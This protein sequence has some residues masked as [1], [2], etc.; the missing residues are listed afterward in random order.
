MALPVSMSA[1]AEPITAHLVLTIEG[2]V[3][4]SQVTP[5]FGPLHAGDTLNA[6][7]LGTQRSRFAPNPASALTASGGDFIAFA[8]ERRDPL[9]NRGMRIARGEAR[10]REEVV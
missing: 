4:E 2:G 10:D 6:V 7:R 8:L 3:A 1:T 9:V 5:L